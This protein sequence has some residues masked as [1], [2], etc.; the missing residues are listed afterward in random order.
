MGRKLMKFMLS[1]ALL[2]AMIPLN[3][4]AVS[5]Y[6]KEEVNLALNKPVTAS[7]EDAEYG[8]LAS[9]AVDG[10]VNQEKADRWAYEMQ[11]PQFLRVDLESKSE[12]K[13]FR[14]VAENDGDQR[15]GQFKIEGSNDDQEYTLI[16]QSE[17]KS[18]EGYPGDL[19]FSVDGDH[20][21]R[22]VKITIEKLKHGAYPSVSLRE[23]E[24]RGYQPDSTEP[25]VDLNSFDNLAFN[26]NVVASGEDV[27]YGFAAS[28][29]VDGIVNDDSKARWAY[30]QAAPQFLRV[31]LEKISELKGFRIVSEND[32]A[33]RI[34]QFKIEGSNNDQDYTLI[35]QSEDKSEEG[36]VQDYRF[37]VDGNH[38]YRYVKI[39]IEKLKH[40]AYPSISLRE[41]EVRGILG[42]DT[43]EG[44]PS[45]YTNIA[46]GKTVTASQQ[47]SQYGMSAEKAVDGIVNDAKRDRWSAEAPPEQ[48]LEV[49]LQASSEIKG[50]RL[51]SENDDTQRIALFKIEGSNNKVDYDVLYQSEDKF[52]EGYPQDTSFSVDVKKHYRYIKVSVQKMKKNAYPSVSLREFEIIGAIK[53]ELIQDD[54]ENVALGKLV[55]TS[56]EEAVSLNGSKL[57]D[58]DKTSRNSRWAS[59]TTNAPHWM[60]IDL[61]SEKNIKSLHL[62]WEG[63]KATSYEIQLS[64]DP[65]LNDWRSVKS[66]DQIPTNKFQKVVLDQVERARY[67][68]LLVNQFQSLDPDSGIDWPNISLYEVEIY[69]GV[70]KETMN[71][72][73]NAIQI[74]TPAFGAKK[75]VV[76]LPD[77]EVFDVKYNGTDIEQIVNDQLE[78]YQPFVDKMVKVSFKITNKA[79]KEYVFKE[80]PV[81]VLGKY[82]DQLGSN[83]APNVLPEV[84]EWVGKEGVYQIQDTTKVVVLDPRLQ[85]VAQVFI[86]DYKDL[87]GNTLSLATQAKAG[88]IVFTMTNDAS[89]GLQ[90][91]GYILDVE[92]Q[93]TITAYDTVGAFWATRTILQSIL[94][95]QQLPKGIVRDYPLYAVRGFILDVGRKTFTLEY[96]KQ[97]VK[98]MAWYKLNDFHIHLN[99]N[100][101]PLENYSRANKDPM[102]AY[103][104]F[105]LES[106]IKQGGEN[107]LYQ[108]DLTSKDVWYSKE[109][110]KQ[111]IHESRIYGVQI[112]P[113]ID[114]PAHSL[115]LTKVRPDLRHGTYG[116]E[117]DHLDLINRYDD[118]LN[119]VKTIFNE[120]LQGS[121]PVFDLDTTIH[122]G[123]DEYTADGNAYRRFSNDLLK[124]IQDSGRKP[125]I[126]GSLSQIKGSVEVLGSG[127]EMNLWNA[128]WSNMK[129]MYDLGFDLINSNDGQY[130]IVPNAGYY[131]DYLS[132][133][134]LY[135][136][137]INHIGGHFIPA[138]D[139]QMLG[140]S[141][142]VWNDMIDILDNGVS[143][144]DVYVRIKPAM[145]LFAAKLWG[146]GQYSLNKAI[147]TSQT[148]QEVPN[149]NFDYLESMTNDTLLHYPFYDLKDV[150]GN[151]RDILTTKNA[152]I[153]E[154]DGKKALHLHGQESY[155]KT[156]LTTV[157]LNNTLSFKV[158]R[159][160][161]SD[162]E[163]ILL[164]S[165]Y[166]SIKAV[167]LETGAV[168]FSREGYH[169]SFH[170]TLPVNQWVELTFE[171]HLDLMKLYVDGKLVDVIGDNEKVGSRPLLATM[172]YP[173]QYIGSQT[174]AFEGYISNVKVGKRSSFVSSV[175]IDHLLVKVNHLG[176]Q[177]KALLEATQEVL[178]KYHPNSNEVED[179][180]NQLQELLKKA[181][182][183]KA[184]YRRIEEYKALIPNDLS[185]FTDESVASLKQVLDSIKP[186]LPRGMQVTVNHYERTLKKAL[187]QLVLK[188]YKNVNYYDVSN[189]NITASSNQNQEDVPQKAFDDNPNTIWHTRWSITTMPHWIQ[190][191]L[192][193]NAVISGIS[194]LPRTTGSL[195]GTILKYRLEKSDNGTDYEVVTSGT[196]KKDRNEKIITFAPTTARFFKLYVLEAVNNNASAA[197]IKLLRNDVLADKDGLQ[198]I[199]HRVEA[200]Y[201]DSYTPESVAQLNEIVAQAKELLKQDQPDS[202][203][204]EQAK[205]QIAFRFARLQ[206]KEYQPTSKEELKGMIKHIQA[207]P[208]ANYTPE[209]FAGVKQA[210]DQ[211]QELLKYD[212][213]TEDELTEVLN[214]LKQALKNLKVKPLKPSVTVQEQESVVITTTPTV[215]D[216][217]ASS[218]VKVKVDTTTSTTLQEESTTSTETVTTSES[219]KE[220]TPTTAIDSIQEDKPST[221]NNLLVY[222]GVVGAIAGA[223]LLFVLWL[224][225]KQS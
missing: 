21:Y 144:Y 53:G 161:T 46:K 33:Q 212:H 89:F 110:F 139:A 180:I 143:E 132:P 138:G 24:V 93:V 57:V 208:Q 22:F 30:E 104:G 25:T 73:A 141:F 164:E 146:K 207:L 119:F 160:S 181:D 45:S 165:P 43:G 5:V 94:H 172:M 182:Y 162:Q 105:R 13:G 128:T 52:E 199:L 103:S 19:Q 153:E 84:S 51:V 26:K 80:I 124:F 135:N 42:S 102:T 50:F 115:A 78:I 193:E 166:G 179:V 91:E 216:V 188:P 213:I 186:N 112:V 15:I 190:M 38:Q 183:K 206:L 167:Q 159:L 34:G 169:Y 63:R 92:D 176:L 125:R 140:G 175:E 40:G 96:L 59:K 163:Q 37:V 47:A 121:D 113:E 8:F 203:D 205:R 69:G 27:Q 174:K 65:A 147:A 10:I 109:D 44:T 154:V 23:F 95:D 74:E 201:L 173:V 131:Y 62:Y 68:R 117:N 31:D 28:K 217:V 221:N 155:V 223:I 194:Y 196:F 76:H 97:V 82:R 145:P 198:D 187:D 32:G 120:Y 150:S 16:Y 72:V 101:I 11:P 107:G 61:G 157:G 4:L 106:D 177:D 79:T 178:K 17:D 81:T 6:A 60:Y 220:E 197:E 168:G 127:Y 126:W 98:L 123:A 219:T 202:L 209:S 14:I 66:F 20:Q 222:L 224:L 130:Y 39:T 64:N 87:T 134:I 55:V 214:T 185:I 192:T 29:A 71:D 18:T 3:N 88:D 83:Q 225:K 100:L 48:W 7:G 36:F 137:E 108:A 148:L 86:N 129:E 54:N 41:F 152:S 9:K 12:I 35:Y 158:K 136:D 171:N 99:D 189:L 2:M 58:G 149:T 70:G 170:Y 210:Y 56:G 85:E 184:D 111:F 215:K 122:I 156:P 75:L 211:A 1:L 133:S 200:H 195:N 191:E 204:V 90:K 114:T 218:K 151:Q 116:R 118:S 77:S 67:V 142:A 49:D